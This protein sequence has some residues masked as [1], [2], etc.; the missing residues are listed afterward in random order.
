[1]T[2]VFSWGQFCPPILALHPVLLDLCPQSLFHPWL[3]CCFHLLPGILRS[4]PRLS[5]SLLGQTLCSNHCEVIFLK[6]VFVS[7]LAKNPSWLPLLTRE[8][9][10]L[11]MRV[12]TGL[13]FLGSPELVGFIQALRVCGFSARCGLGGRDKKRREHCPDQ[14]LLFPLL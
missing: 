3:L 12:T 14:V 5:R 7:T 10:F 9:H 1:M 8:H 13:L 6:P 2:L 11:S 4:P